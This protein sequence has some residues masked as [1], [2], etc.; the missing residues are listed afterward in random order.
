MS[1]AQVAGIPTLVDASAEQIDLGTLPVLVDASVQQVDIASMPI[2]ID[3]SVQQINIAS[4]AFLID[5]ILAPPGV[6]PAQ[7]LR[8]GGGL[9]D[10]TL[11]AFGSEI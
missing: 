10:G 8:H 6:T 7:R 3:A 5:A 2:L 11:Y 1:D 9:V 4:L